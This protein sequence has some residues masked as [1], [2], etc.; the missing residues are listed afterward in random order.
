[1]TFDLTTFDST[2]ALVEAVTRHM[3]SVM[4]RALDDHN[5][6]SLALAGGGTPMPIYAHL[7]AAGL[8]FS[9]VSAVPTDERWVAIDH[10][11][12]NHRQIAQQFDG[13]TIQLKRLVPDSPGREPDSTHAR[14]VLSSMPE[15]FD[16]VLLGM[17][18]DGHFASLFPGSPALVQGLDPDGDEHVLTV[19]PD[20]LPPEAPYARVT[21]TLFRLLKSQHSMLV[22][23][24]HAKRE[25]LERAARPDAN[26]DK[27][28]VAALL[29]EAGDRLDIFW[30]P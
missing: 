23:T 24:G 3:R 17:G 4:S 8:D 5:R 29:K 27:L 1:M 19:I 9:R 26:P 7:G 10:E 30:S 22:I 13:T 15:P 11:H 20:P 18:T 25:V 6:A 28:P 2:Q 14:R 21:L 12:S 16:L